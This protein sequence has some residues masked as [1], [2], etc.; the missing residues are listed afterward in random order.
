MAIKLDDVIT[1]AKRRIGITDMS[2][3]TDSLNDHEAYVTDEAMIGFI[4]R[5]LK[6]ISSDVKAVHLLSHIKS[7]TSNTLP[8]NFERILKTRV[9]VDSVPAVFRDYN[10]IRRQ[11]TTSRKPTA[12]NPVWTI[13]YNKIERYPSSGVLQFYYLDSIPKAEASLEDIE[14]SR[15]LQSILLHR[16]LVEYYSA[17][18]EYDKVEVHEILYRLEV[19][20]Y[21]INT[22]FTVKDDKETDTEN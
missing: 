5:G 8:V 13:R 20:P 16:V 7:T 18:G 4:N 9:L 17:I 21:I 10:S 1:L 11:I 19:S 22:A 6:R 12:A 15:K 2:P 14:I 3:V